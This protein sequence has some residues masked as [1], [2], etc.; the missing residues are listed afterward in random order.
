MREYDARNAINQ[1]KYERKRQKLID[2]A[3]SR[4]RLRLNQMEIIMPSPAI[5]SGGSHLTPTPISLT[6][7][8]P[9]A[10]NATGVAKMHTLRRSIRLKVMAGAIP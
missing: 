5:D 8:S 7:P 6:L 1:H 4:M 9:T 3:T 2:L 10:A